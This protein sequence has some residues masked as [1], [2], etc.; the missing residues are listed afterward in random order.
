MYHL[1]LNLLSPANTEYETDCA[2]QQQVDE[3]K[4]DR[5]NHDHQENEN[6]RNQG[7]IARRPGNLAKFRTH[8]LKVLNEARLLDCR[9]W[10][11]SGRGRGLCHGSLGGAGIPKAPAPIVPV[12]HSIE[13]LLK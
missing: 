2:A 12:L 8:V 5:G 9:L 7:L 4:E 6:S 3:E 13:R 10:S 1:A 11:R